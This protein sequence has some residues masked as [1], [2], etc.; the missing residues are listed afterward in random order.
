MLQ[1][2]ATLSELEE[3]TSPKRPESHLGSNILMEKLPRQQ[4]RQQILYMNRT[5]L[6]NIVRGL[7]SQ[8]AQPHVDRTSP[9]SNLF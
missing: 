3:Y 6:E 9:N 1:T 5:K 2:P 8:Y 4:L 7:G